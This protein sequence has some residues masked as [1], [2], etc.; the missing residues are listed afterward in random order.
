MKTA[1]PGMTEDQRLSDVIRIASNVGLIGGYLL[2]ERLRKTPVLDAATVPPSVERVTPEWLTAVLCQGHPGA[3]V[4]GFELGTGSSGTSVRRQLLLAYNEEGSEAGLPASVFAKTAP[5]LLT[6]IGTGL[7]GIAR[8][9]AGFY[10]EI[11]PFLDL[12][13]PLGYHADWS[14]RSFRSV[15][16]LED[17]VATKGATFC[18]PTNPVSPSQ[19]EEI[20]D[21]LATLHGT[22]LQGPNHPAVPP[23]VRTYRQWW[24]AVIPTANIKRYHH[25]GFHDAAE[26]VP[27]ELRRHGSDVWPAFVRSVELHASL[28]ATLIHGDVHLGNWYVTAAGAMGL[29]DWQCIALG[30]WSRDLAYA[31]TTTLPVE[32]RRRLERPLVE[33]YVERLNSLADGAITVPEAWLGYRQQMV[34]A[35]LMWTPTHSPPRIA[36]KNM[37]PREVARE[38]IHRITTAMVDQ[39]ALG[40]LPRR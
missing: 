18:S 36:P 16:L 28:P 15:Q 32:V 4:V 22:F 37:Q 30:H 6:R 11:R 5:G 13:A 21:L 1:S 8:A 25:R 29:C 9:E 14:P 26:G 2:G 7:T 31:L 27:A 17:L 10:Q 35:L 3:R 19:A 33:R 23:W 24:D 12:E 40:S 34:G 38:M 39:D 20:V